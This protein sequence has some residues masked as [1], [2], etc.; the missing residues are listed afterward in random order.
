[1][2]NL[3]PQT[4]F[5]QEWHIVTE[6]KLPVSERKILFFTQ[7][8]QISRLRSQ[9]LMN[10]YEFPRKYKNLPEGKKKKKEAE[11]QCKLSLVFNV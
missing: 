11:L 5:Q 1:M 4:Q 6:K 3:N 10:F 9:T 8:F 7:E 2:Y